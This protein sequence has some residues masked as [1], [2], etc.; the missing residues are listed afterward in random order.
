M[1][2]RTGRYG[3]L[4]A[5]HPEL[6]DASRRVLEVGA[7]AG[8]IAHYLQRAVT[9]VD[10]AFPDAVSPHLSPVRA[11]IL[12]LPF[13]DG[14]FDDVV[15][16]DL[17][18]ELAPNDF[19]A[20]IAELVRVAG[21]GVMIAI[22]AGTFAASADAAYAHQLARAGAAVPERLRAPPMRAIPQLGD[23]FAALL[24]TGYAF[25]VRR[26]EGVLQHYAEIFVDSAAFLGRFLRAHNLKFPGEA[27]L[28]AAEGDLPYS[29]LLTID[30]IATPA[31]GRGSIRT[32]ALAAPPLQARPKPPR[33]A[34]FAVGH[35]VDRLPAFPGV[36]R[37]L[38]GGNIATPSDPDVLRDDVGPNI[39]DRNHAYSEMTAIYWVWRNM[40]HL[41]AV[42]FCH[43]RRYFDFRPHA[44]RPQRETYLHTADDV[45]ACQ[46]RFADHSVI[47]RH[48]A[49]GAI[50]VAQPM[51][52]DAC[53]PEQYMLGHLP[54]HYLAMVNH[55]LA[56]HP[57]YDGQ[58][59][60]QA[61]DRSLFGSNMFVMPWAEFDRLCRFWFDCLFGIEKSLGTLRPGYHGR[62][63]A[64]LSE[65]IFDLHV[66]RLRDSG[67]QIVDYPIF[68][69]R[70][71]AFPASA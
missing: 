46:A 66:R 57:D 1:I 70:D 42:G 3:P 37:I 43:Y 12:R 16:T 63:L 11:S 55:V 53:N 47:G 38:A 5:C 35:R 39:A 44:A 58:L 60:A 68:C 19:P 4:I 65:R 29:Y 15:C 30:K 69:L 14:A 26:S 71:S 31:S 9:G 45:Q 59:L 21:K 56:H 64:F 23:L 52:L 50:V 22:P 27:P 67:Q 18:P 2:G 24:A 7:G 32:L 28:L 10:R 36:R 13:R 34:L 48:L 54:E 49:E 8:G 6:F 62:A 51:L 40:R 61:R 17:L 20:A 25:T 41:D 33:V